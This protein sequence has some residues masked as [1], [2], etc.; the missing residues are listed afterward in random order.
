MSNFLPKI[1][2]DSLGSEIIEGL[3]S[4]K[5]YISSKF[6]YD[7][8]GSKLFEE[9][10]RL[11]EYYLTRIEKS[12]LK[13]AAKNI[14]NQMKDLDI[15]ELGSGDDSKISILFNALPDEQIKSVNYIPVDVSQAAM[16]KSANILLKKFPS[17]KI[18]GVVADFTTQ[19]KLIP[20]RPKHIFCFFG[21]TIGNFTKEQAQQFM[22]NLSEV[23]L[24]GNSL[25]LGV[26]MVKNKE[27]LE[28]A[29]NDSRNVTEAF[30]RNI[31]N[32]VNSL[33]GTDF[34]PRDFEHLAFY[35]QE[36]SRIEMH[37]KAKK[38]LE[39]SCPRL[40]NKIIIRKRESIHTENSYKYTNESINKLASTSGLKIKN[41]FTDKNNW[42]SVIQLY[43]KGENSL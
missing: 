42:F 37:L 4:D 22:N 32:V 35:S 34:N 26:D 5:K 19:L 14:T 6:F 11:P 25:L 13:R 15:I 39:I 40:P 31:L 7:A 3:T 24:S 28:K 33:I 9:I 29:Y 1:G 43:K 16:E 17:L 30:N 20:A 23:M 27:I 8:V 18:H 36:H 38:D 41:R 21:S 12:I 10:T 2:K